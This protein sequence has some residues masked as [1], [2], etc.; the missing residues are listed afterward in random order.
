MASGLHYI[1][2]DN[3]GQKC[4]SSVCF[5]KAVDLNNLIAKKKI[6]SVNIFVFKNSNKIDV[7]RE[8]PKVVLEMKI[9]ELYK[10]IYSPHFK[11]NENFL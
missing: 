5:S 3:V 10:K 11:S 7:F 1:T 2:C 8:W 6:V 9:V 4:Y